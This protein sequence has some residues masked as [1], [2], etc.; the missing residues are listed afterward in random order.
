MMPAD[1][2]L[3]EIL[4][5]DPDRFID[6]TKGRSTQLYSTLSKGVHW[7]FF[8]S[9]IIFDDATIKNSIREAILL[10]AN[11]GLASH[12][13]HTAYASLDPNVAVDCYKAIRRLIP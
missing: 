12:F 7:E 2:L 9:A 13:V 10:M 3:T 4:S 5:I 11:L 6:E 8:T 1:A